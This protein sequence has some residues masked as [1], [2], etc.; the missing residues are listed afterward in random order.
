M[1]LL[2]YFFALL[3]LA[4][5]GS[6]AAA[7]AGLYGL[8]YYG[9]DLPDYQQLANYQPPVT[10]RVHAGDGRLIAE[11]ARERRLFVPIAAM[12]NSVI[13][14]FLSAEDKNFFSHAGIDPVGIARAVVQNVLNVAQNRRPVGASTITQQV[15][16][17]FL[18]G[19]E[20]SL[21]RKAKEAILAFRIER[22]FSKEKILELYLN[23][24]YLGAGAYGVA[25]AALT[26]F[27]KS[28]YD[29]TI[30]EAAYLAGL[31]KAPSSYHPTRQNDRA[32]ARR[33]YV[34][35][36]MLEDAVITREEAKAARD[37]PLVAVTRPETE[38]ARADWFA[39]EVRRSLAQRYGDKGLYEG[40]LSVRATMDPVLQAAGEKALRDGLVAYD[41]RAG[42]WRGPLARLPAST[43][44]RLR[45]TGL[46]QQPGTIPMGAILPPWR[47]ATVISVANDAAEIGFGDGSTGRIAYADLRWARAKLDTSNGN[48]H[49]VQLGPVPKSAAD[50]LQPGDVII[51]DPLPGQKDAYALRQI[52]EV[53]GALV[54]MD[55]HTGR[56]LALV[57]GFDFKVSQF[58]RATQAMRQPGSSFKPFV[59]AAALDNGF[60]PASLVLDAPFVLDQGPGL[61][62][63]KPG[64]YT[65]E[66]YGPSTLRVGIEKSRNLMTVRLAQAIGMEKVVGY[67]KRFGIVDDMPN[68]LS[69][70]LGAGETTLMKLTTAYAELVNGGR[71][72]A[73]TLIDKVQDRQGRTIFRHDARPCDA[74]RPTAFEG[75]AEP[76]LPDLRET[77]LDPVTAYQMVSMLEGVVQRGTGVRLREL[78]KPVAGKTG[79][80]NDSFDTWFMGFSPDLAVGVF[81]GYDTPRDLGKRET[82]A[83]V[84]VPV[85]RDFMAEA[86]KTRP[87][88][89]FRVPPG[90]R[91][92]RVQAD[93]GLPA[94]PGDRGV[95]LEAFR[96]GTEPTGERNVLDG[97]LYEREAISGAGGS[98]G[99][100]P[101]SGT[102]GLY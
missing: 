87:G 11:F 15:A 49:A 55:P 34:I 78:G 21:S 5:L 70:S 48:T 71:K 72:I 76:A 92:V 88:I 23:E 80:S 77:V 22:A 6:L 39:E 93:T 94:Q 1:R 26:Y 36:R 43:D 28:L 100:A 27:D 35:D 4:L 33:D 31:P 32:K 12:P 59:Y 29:L 25:A 9:R 82:G 17:N 54:A 97:S 42:G 2:R 63:W 20:V 47:I 38:L 74:C 67:A 95:I 44:W 62:L 30:A 14:A 86:L 18:L 13:Q 89:Q 52:P 60:T 101:T 96:P 37:T 99:A 3:F 90:V 7:A 69:M 61:P 68:V 57:G 75:Q 40:G 73:P 85:W 51:A 81:V 83:S 41:R 66:F 79:T 91:L 102:G 46:Q 84:A 64:N 24:I 58:N 16:K 65:R 45:I 50:V 53:G 98:A 8:W 56:V 10:T 19:N